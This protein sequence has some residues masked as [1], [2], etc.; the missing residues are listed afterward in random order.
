MAE[1]KDILTVRIIRKKHTVTCF[2]EDKVANVI[3]ALRKVPAGSVCDEFTI[4]CEGVLTMQF[5]DE[6][7]DKGTT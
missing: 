5:H 7:I 6:Q 3:D 4:N 2:P 1:Y